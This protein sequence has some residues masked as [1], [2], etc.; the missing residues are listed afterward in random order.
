[1]KLPSYERVWKVEKKIYSLG[2]IHL[3]APIKPMDFL[4]YAA[5][6]GIV[7]LLDSIIPVLQPVPWIIKYLVVPFLLVRFLQK[8]KFDGKPP[9]KF[10]IDYLRYLG[11]R[12]RQLESFRFT[13]HKPKERIRLRWDCSFRN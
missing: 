10:L 9:Q 6:L 8:K 12:G 5:V 4:Y 2:N 3:P 13:A 11:N 7:L 1:M